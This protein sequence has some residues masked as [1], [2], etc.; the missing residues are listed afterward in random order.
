MTSKRPSA[1]ARPVRGCAVPACQRP[2]TI[3]LLTR[4]RGG[5]SVACWYC[6]LHRSKIKGDYRV[7]LI[8][9]WDLEAWGMIGDS[10]RP[11]I[12]RDE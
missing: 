8:P 7:V 11:R 2:G 3:P 6:S 1:I 12:S 4:H 10:P 5:W 9:E